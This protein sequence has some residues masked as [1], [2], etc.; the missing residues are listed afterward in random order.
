MSLHGI[1]RRSA[2]RLGIPLIS[3]SLGLLAVGTVLAGSPGPSA[4]QVGQTGPLTVQ[5]SGTWIWSEMAS[6]AKPS[7]AGFA[8]DWGDTTSGNEVG[9]YHIGDGTPATNIVLQPT[10]PAQGSSGSFGPVSHTYARTG[11]YTVCA[12]IYDLGQVKPFKTTGYHSLQAG[13][14]GRNTDNSVDQ[15]M[16]PP[17]MCATIEVT[18]PTQSPDASPT[19]FESFAGATSD[20]ATTPPPTSTTTGPSSSDPGQP[21]LW[22]A[23]LIGSLLA[24]AFALRRTRAKR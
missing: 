14:T 5:A 19:P 4:I 9:S 17:V 3:V 6:A 21:F 10:N 24:T 12:I 8:I 22:L 2:L 16:D 1:R 18:A 11:T 23:P 7:Y 20:P 15:R 13:G